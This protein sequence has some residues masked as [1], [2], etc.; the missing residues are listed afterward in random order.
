[1]AVL[2]ISTVDLVKG[3]DIT[4]LTIDSMMHEAKTVIWYLTAYF[5]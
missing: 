4:Y 1:M 5:D 3:G 2:S